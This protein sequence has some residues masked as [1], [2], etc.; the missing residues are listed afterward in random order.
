MDRGFVSTIGTKSEF[1][2]KCRSI[3]SMIS[4]DFIQTDKNNKAKEIAIRNYHCSVCSMFVLSENIN[5]NINIRGI[6]IS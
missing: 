2:P 4:S 3:Q 1:C 5:A 6:S